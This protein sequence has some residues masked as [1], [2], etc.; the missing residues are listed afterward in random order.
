MTTGVDRLDILFSVQRALLGEVRPNLRVVTA[1][2]DD[3]H[4]VISF[5]FDG[6]VS[7]DDRETAS[8]I[9]TEVIAYFPPAIKI[10]A[11]C[12]RVDAPERIT[13]G[14]LWIYAR[15]EPP[16]SGG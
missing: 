15:K 8:E 3:S 10:A 14:G 5:Y 13:D 9:E 7:D 16:I 11:N 2:Y 6:P 1:N 12:I 4:V